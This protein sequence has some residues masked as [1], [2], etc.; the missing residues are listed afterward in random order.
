M[1]VFDMWE[2]EKIYISKKSHLL[3]LHFS[4]QYLWCL[5]LDV[6]G[7]DIRVWSRCY[8]LLKIPQPSKEYKGSH[9]VILSPIYLYKSA[10]NI[11]KKVIN[12]AWAELNKKE[13][14]VK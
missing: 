9:F 7:S 1:T 11:N 3:T 2:K 14:N 6:S 5:D 8:R 12:N 13:V 4:Q 10:E